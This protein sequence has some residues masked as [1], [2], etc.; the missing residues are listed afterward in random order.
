MVWQVA[1][2]GLHLPPSIQASRQQITMLNRPD[3]PWGSLNIPLKAAPAL[4]S[5]ASFETVKREASAVGELKA[6]STTLASSK[7]PARRRVRGFTCCNPSLKHRKGQQRCQH[8]GRPAIGAGVITIQPCTRHEGSDGGAHAEQ[9]DALPGASNV[10]AW[11][12][13]LGGNILRPHL[14]VSRQVA[15]TDGQDRHRANAVVLSRLL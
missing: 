5:L 3:S 2:T 12:G 8:A 11:A 7:S 6:E 4:M 9:P 14:H 1:Q 15:F 10:G 13:H